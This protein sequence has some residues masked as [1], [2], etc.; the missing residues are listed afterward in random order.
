MLREDGEYSFG[1]AFVRC[2]PLN[3]DLTIPVYDRIIAGE[4]PFDFSGV[5][6]ISSIAFT[7]KIDNEDAQTIN[8]DLS[9]VGTQHAVTATELVNAI[10]AEAPTDITASVDGTTGRVTLVYDGTE[11]VDY[12]QVYGEAALI[13]MFGQ[14]LG[15]KF[16]KSDTIRE[17]TD[18]PV[19][20]EEE[21]I[22]TTDAAGLDTSVITD[23]YRKGF[24]LTIT[25]TVLDDWEMQALMEGGTYD[26]TAD[27]YEVPTS[28]DSKIYFYIEAFYYYYTEG[29]NKE[30]DI[31]G[32]I[33][34]FYRTC[35]GAI[36]DNTHG[37]AFSDGNY[38]VSGTSYK[39]EDGDLYGDTQKKRYTV[40]EY[41]A[42]YVD[43][44]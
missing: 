38:T 32:Y 37:R 36:G 11:S 7:T 4:G 34:K 29:E 24:T 30:A 6:D 25:D 31:A 2:M 14:G 23:G 17:I 43:T 13:G 44:I 9:G 8:I 33:R 27:T 18:T 26:A 22:T 1:L 42:L 21:T 3:D 20:K 10:N 40:E 16:I 39:D 35:K 12:L 41:A 19:V 15:N 28:E 5:D